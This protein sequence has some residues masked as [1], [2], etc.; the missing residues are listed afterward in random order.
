MTGLIHRLQGTKRLIHEGQVM[1][2]FAVA[3]LVLIGAVALAV[4]VGYLLAERRQ[5]QAAADAAAMAAAQS[6]LDNK[7]SEIISA[8]QYYGALNA[9]VAESTVDVDPDAAGPSGGDG[10]RY[11]EVTI[12]KS[13]QKFFLGA[14]YPGSWT[15]T[16]AAMAA[17]E[18]VDADYALITLD[19]S[20]IPGIYMNGNTGIVISGDG[21]GA[22][23][24]TTI[25]GGS[26]TTFDVE[27]AIHAYGEI[28]GSSGWDAPK[29]VQG[30]RNR[31]VEDPIVKA[32]VV[33]PSVPTQVRD[34][35]YID[36]CLKQNPCQLDPG[37]Y[38]SVSISM[39]NKD[40]INLSSGLY[41]FDG[42]SSFDLKNKSEL[43]GTGVQ[44][45]FTG[46]SSF[47]PKN[48]DVNL[49]V[50]SV[51]D[52]TTGPEDVVIWVDNCSDV[53]LQGNGEMRFEGIFYAPCSN[54]LMHGNPST[55]TIN[56]QIIVGT[57]DL[58]GTSDLGI[59]YRQRVETSQP[60]VFLI[61]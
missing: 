45:Y 22:A 47:K 9:G 40:K 11:V 43:T 24:N 50:T 19:K 48:G 34:Q 7:K 37:R 17:V 39:G 16:A 18:P 6:G 4:D 8:G 59:T 38:T 51:P 14:I 26:N 31:Y 55:E 28:T 42:T 57:L 35:K 23:S 29:G 52:D 15:V 44:L 30:N 21:G 25:Q 46:G 5:V 13:V 2:L 58:K 53:D 20:E 54:A 49:K 60:S 32:G 36:D 27:G 12:T 1:I 3:S 33:A 10:E 56:G 41:Y 61:N